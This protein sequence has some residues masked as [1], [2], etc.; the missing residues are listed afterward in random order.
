MAIN[1]G[2]NADA[3]DALGDPLEFDQRGNGFPR[4]SEGTVDIGAFED[5]TPTLTVSIDP[6]S[7][8]ENGGTSA[9]TVTITRNTDTF[10][11]LTVNLSSDDTSEAT[12]PA[13]VSFPPERLPPRSPSQQS[14]T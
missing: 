2:T 10:V 3:V 9:A 12:V 13:T 11:N 4:I 7:I 1:A 5:F 8:P 14:M 6:A